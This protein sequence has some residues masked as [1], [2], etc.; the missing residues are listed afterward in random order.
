MLVIRQKQFLG[1]HLTSLLVG[2]PFFG[3]TK[4]AA[5]LEGSKSFAQSFVQK[6]KIPAPR[7]HVFS[8]H[9]DALNFAKNAGFQVVVK[10][11]G[12]TGSK[13]VVI[14]RDQH[15]VEKV[16]QEMLLDQIWAEAGRVVVLE[17]LLSGQELTI[18]VV[19]DGLCFK[20]LSCVKDYKR[21]NDGDQGV[22][23]GGMGS[24]APEEIPTAVMKTIEQAIIQPTID[25][26]REDG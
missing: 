13:G 26:M 2:I 14:A 22:N 11:S 24:Y 7:A 17:E 25:G 4:L 12:L 10:A 9:Q 19:S 1:L 23:T 8:S 16:L 6:H 5:Q 15:V 21:L 18:T 3:P 20:T